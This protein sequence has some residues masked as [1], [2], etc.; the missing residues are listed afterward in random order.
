MVYGIIRFRTQKGRSRFRCGSGQSRTAGDYQ[1]RKTEHDTRH[2]RSVAHDGKGSDDPA[3]RRRFYFRRYRTRRTHGKD[4]QK[5]SLAH[6]CVQR[7]HRQCRRHTLRQRFDS[8]FR[9]SRNG[10]SRKDPPQSVFYSRIE[11]YRFAPSRV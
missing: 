5:R 3:Y 8:H 10:R 11:A 1:R 2:R 6:S 4:R 9:F 7:I